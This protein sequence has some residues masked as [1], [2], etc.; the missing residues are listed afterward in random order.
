[1]IGALQVDATILALSIEIKL[2]LS[3]FF[4]WIACWMKATLTEDSTLTAGFFRFHS[5]SWWKGALK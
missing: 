1:M 5:F 3:I 2:F 4:H